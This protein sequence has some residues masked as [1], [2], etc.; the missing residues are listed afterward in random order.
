MAGPTHTMADK[1]LCL[2]ASEA[3]YRH[4]DVHSLYGWAQTEPTLR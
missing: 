2:A 3:P 4:Y 1:T